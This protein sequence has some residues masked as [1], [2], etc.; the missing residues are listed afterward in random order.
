[1]SVIY[2]IDLP[3]RSIL[4]LIFVLHGVNKKISLWKCRR[5]KMFS[6]KKKKKV[7]DTVN[8]PPPAPPGSVE[9]QL[10]Q[11][12]SVQANLGSQ[13][14]LGSQLT[15]LTQDTAYDKSLGPNSGS[16]VRSP[17]SSMGGVAFSPPPRPSTV[18]GSTDPQRTLYCV[19]DDVTLTSKFLTTLRDRGLMHLCND[20]PGLDKILDESIK[21]K[22]IVSAYMAFD[23]TVN[24]LSLLP[25]LMVL[26]HFQKCGHKPFVLISEGGMAE[27]DVVA[28]DE[29]ISFL[30][31]FLE[32]ESSVDLSTTAAAIVNRNEYNEE[33]LKITEGVHVAQMLAIESVKESLQTMSCRDFISNFNNLTNRCGAFLAM[34]RKFGVVLQLDTAAQYSDIMSGLA[35][36]CLKNAKLFG[37]TVPLIKTSDGNNFGE[38]DK[39]SSLTLQSISKRS[40]MDFWNATAEADIIRFFKLFTEWPLEQI[41]KLETTMKGAKSSKQKS[42]SLLAQHA[43]K[44]V[45]WE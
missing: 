19:T 25:K 29:I 14:T 21:N 44:V 5:T 11:N 26:R 27:T 45:Q 42:K 39:G 38:N 6:K 2:D 10:Q 8:P 3:R 9:P 28:N 13:P 35:L 30:K 22:T 23:F 41:T 1:M 20:A 34:H 36:G 16:S 33:L 40:Y 17:G 32:I 15:Q 31:K 18:D 4:F 37:L 12:R 7:E 43:T 24:L